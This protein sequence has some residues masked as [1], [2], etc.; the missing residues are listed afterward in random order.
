MSWEET[1]K[2]CDLNFPT[3]FRHEIT[4]IVRNEFE[5]KSDVKGYHPYINSWKPI[6]G[7][8][9]KTHSEAENV[10]KKYAVAVLKDT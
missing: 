10:M 9:L 5:T 4:V 3:S 7:E 2:L 6:I 8:N 1:V